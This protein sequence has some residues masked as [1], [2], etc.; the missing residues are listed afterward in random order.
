MRYRTVE[1]KIWV[2]IQRMRSHF[3]GRGTHNPAAPEFKAAAIIVYIGQEGDDMILGYDVAV[4]GD[5]KGGPP[6]YTVYL[7]GFGGKQVEGHQLFHVAAQDDQPPPLCPPQSHPTLLPGPLKPEM[8][9][10]EERVSQVD[11]RDGQDSSE[12]ASGKQET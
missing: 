12:A 4:H 8:K 3:Y 6:F 9:K 1:K 10:G 11:V 5:G 2:T 7:E